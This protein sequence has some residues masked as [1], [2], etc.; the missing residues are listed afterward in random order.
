MSLFKLASCFVS[1]YH[2]F[3][4]N[5]FIFKLSTCCCCCKENSLNPWCT[6]ENSRGDADLTV[7]VFYSENKAENFMWVVCPQFT[8]N[9][10]LNLHWKIRRKKNLIRVFTVCKNSLAIFS[11]GIYVSKSHSRMYLKWT[12]QNLISFA[13]SLSVC[14]SL[15]L[16]LGC[17]LFLPSWYVSFRAISLHWLYWK[18]WYRTGGNWDARPDRRF[19]PH[20]L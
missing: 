11:L 2:A 3:F 15:S 12:N 8:C 17:S 16:S 19:D 6:A 5:H 14:L 20:R 13:N 9:V 10:T 18:E 4:S 1:I 7:L